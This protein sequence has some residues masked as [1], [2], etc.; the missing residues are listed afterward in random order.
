RCA[1]GARLLVV[2]GRPGH[3]VLARVGALVER[4]SFVAYLAGRTS[5]RLF[6]GAGGG[7]WPAPD[8]DAALDAARL[9]RALDRR[10]K[11]YSHGMKQRLGLAQALL[12]GPEVLVLDEPTTG[13]DPQETREIRHLVRRLAE[14]GTTILL[15]SHLL[16]E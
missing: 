9:G 12:N 15:S 4:P 11:G 8:L 13:L 6:W 5:L 3:R 16:A 2:G 7:A 10:V 14:G 1:G